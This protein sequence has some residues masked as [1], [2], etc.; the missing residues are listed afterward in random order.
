MNIVWAKN[1]GHCIYVDVDI[2]NAL[3]PVYCTTIWKIDTP[4]NG[5][6]PE[7]KRKTPLV[8]THIQR[9][10]DSKGHWH[11]AAITHTDS[12]AINLRCYYV[13][14]AA[15]LH[16]FDVHVCRIREE[17]IGNIHNMPARNL[18]A[19]VVCASAERVFIIFYRY[20]WFD[21]RPQLN[22]NNVS[23]TLFIGSKCHSS[24]WSIAS[25]C[26]S[27]AIRTYR[28]TAASC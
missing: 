24:D 19:T 3:C 4:S 5:A 17:W 21:V 6:N 11:C 13:C 1:D 9:R 8:D 22:E 7:R 23:L 27:A 26:M 20:H 14:N 28:H 12:G 16:Q 18:R 10:I 25:K 15:K 2:E